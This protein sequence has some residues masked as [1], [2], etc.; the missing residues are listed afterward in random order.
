MSSICFAVTGKALMKQLMAY[1]FNQEL[2][3]GDVRASNY[4]PMT[5]LQYAA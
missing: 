1:K 3:I 4:Y 5:S 2:A